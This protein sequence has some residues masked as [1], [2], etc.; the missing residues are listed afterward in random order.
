MLRLRMR[1]ADRRCDGRMVWDGYLQYE[2][3]ICLLCG[4]GTAENRGKVEMRSFLLFAWMHYQND[5]DLQCRA[6]NV[7]D[8]DAMLV[9]HFKS[10]GGPERGCRLVGGECDASCLL[11]YGVVVGGDEVGEREGKRLQERKVFHIQEPAA[12]VAMPCDALVTRNGGSHTQCSKLKK[13]KKKEKKS[14]IDGD[15]DV[16]EF[17]M[18][19]DTANDMN[20]R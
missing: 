2:D 18:K 9:T 12:S 13:K 19:S 1:N 7:V 16:A 10:R 14:L 17:G 3:Q 6:H 20:E 5:V 11:Q 15:R 8:I 4:L